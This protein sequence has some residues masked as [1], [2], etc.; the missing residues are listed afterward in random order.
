M[1]WLAVALLLAGCASLPCANPVTDPRGGS[2]RCT[3]TCRPCAATACDLRCA[4]GYTTSATRT[5]SGNPR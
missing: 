4:D 5:G 1:R 3:V 2:V